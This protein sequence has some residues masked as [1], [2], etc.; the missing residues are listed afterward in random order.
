M[1]VILR[2]GGRFAALMVFLAVMILVVAQSGTSPGKVRADARI[3]HLNA[4]IESVKRQNLVMEEL[5]KFRRSDN[6][7][8]ATAK[9]ELGLTERD[10]ISLDVRG[11]QD[12]VVEKATVP[13]AVTGK[14]P[15]KA[16]GLLDFGY[17]KAWVAR[18]SGSR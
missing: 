14:E 6:F 10:D 18:L 8:I 2:F 17:I 13:A 4:Q 5:V 9:R 3:S 11:I 7:V 1:G 15:G 12:G 16:N